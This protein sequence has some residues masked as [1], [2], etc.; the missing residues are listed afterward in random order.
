ME[1]AA[2]IRQEI[3]DTLY[4]TNA[5]HQSLGVIFEFWVRS[6][7]DG[8]EYD[9]TFSLAEQYDINMGEESY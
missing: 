5:N 8:V 9:I 2:I 6:H 1:I 4:E 3:M 7:F